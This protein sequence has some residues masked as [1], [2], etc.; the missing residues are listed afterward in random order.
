MKRISIVSLVGLFL[1]LSSWVDVHPQSALIRL[2]PDGSLLI[3]EKA[4]VTGPRILQ[5]DNDLELLSRSLPVRIIRSSSPSWA[6][7]PIITRGGRG[8][9]RSWSSSSPG[10]FQVA[11]MI[12]KY[13]Q[14]HGVDP[15]LVRLVVQKESGFNTQA[16]SPKGAMGLMQLM[17]GTASLLG[18]QDP[19]DPEQN[20]AGGVR[21][22]KLCLQRFNNNLCLAL[23]AYNA[24]PENVARYQG[25]PPFAETQNYVASIMREYTGKD[26]P[27][28]AT[29]GAPPPP[30]APSPSPAAELKIRPAGLQPLY[31]GGQG[32]LSIIQARKAKIITIVPQ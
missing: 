28:P 1:L 7:E 23:A 21:Y 20:I 10:D 27:V 5:P 3:A 15:G 32:R 6:G 9:V 31:V 4:G 11:A 8:R 29:F 19:F 30:S 17:P 12:R 18:V 26:V 13:A 16:V 22:L 25:L 24:G 2:S 14:E